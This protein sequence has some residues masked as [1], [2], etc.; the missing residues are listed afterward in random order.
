MTTK[1]PP[2]HC[3]VPGTDFTVDWH[4]RTEPRFVHSFLSHAHED[5]LAGVRSFRL[6]RLLHCTP[7]TA[8]LL[9]IKVPQVRP[10]LVL[11]E[12]NSEFTIANTTIRVLDAHHTAGSAMFLFTLQDGRRILHTGDFRAEPRVVS[13]I[14]PFAPIDHLFIDCTFAL[15]SLEIPRRD[16]CERFVV[17]LARARIA[18]G[19][20]VL[21]GTYTIG[22]ETLIRDVAKAL[23]H[24]VWAN[25]DR[26]KGLE[27]VFGGDNLLTSEENEAFLHVVSMEAASFSGVLGYAAAHGKTKVVAVQLTGWAGKRGW[28]TPQVLCEGGVE[29]IVYKVPYSDHSSKEELVEF[30]EAVK[31]AKVTPTTHREEKK[32]NAIMKMFLPHMRKEKNKTFIEFYC[33]K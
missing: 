31:P 32:V 16:V 20:T 6:P 26:M 28:R 8:R 21:L 29:A 18:Q 24:R 19:Y 25:E 4:C 27:F 15:E 10:C 9:L 11:H 7:V 23:G 12:P 13:S 17:E 2:R 14:L 3:V 5:H 1:L 22:K 30:V 33:K